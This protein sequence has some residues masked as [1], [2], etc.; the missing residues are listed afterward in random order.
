M[1]LTLRLHSVCQDRRTNPYDLRIDH[2]EAAHV[3][4][5]STSD[6]RYQQI[7]KGTLSRRLWRGPAGS[8]YGVVWSHWGQ[9]CTLPCKGG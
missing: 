8:S 3:H 7:Y 6:D 2:P 5:S 9:G 1:R 4:L